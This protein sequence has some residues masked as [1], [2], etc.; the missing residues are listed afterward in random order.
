MRDELYIALRAI[1]LRTDAAVVRSAIDAHESWK[2]L[3]FL[4]VFGL[5][6]LPLWII[7]HRHHLLAS[8]QKPWG[9]LRCEG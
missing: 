2:A 6:F 7:T 3:E 1:H 4:F 5:I 9:S 8:A